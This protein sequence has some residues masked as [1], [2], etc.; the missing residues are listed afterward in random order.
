MNFDSIDLAFGGGAPCVI[1]GEIGVNHN[2]DVDILMRL[3]E[4]GA[5]AGLDVLKLQHFVAEEEI[6]RYAPS[7]DY[8]AAGGHADGQLALA[9]ALELSGETLVKA[10]ARCRALGVGFLCSVFDPVSAAFVAE[11]LGCKSVKIASSE[12]GAEPFLADL[13]RKFDGLILSTGASELSETARAVETLRAH[14]TP[15]DA[16][17]IAVMHCVSEYPAPMRD[18]NLKTMAALEIALGVPVGFS[19]HTEGLVAGV[20]AAALGAAVLEKHYTLDKALP[21]PDHK[22]SAD[23]AEITAYVRAVRDAEAAL[24][25]GRKTPAPSEAGNRALIRKSLVCAVEALA[26]GA[27]IEPSMLAA[28][29][30]MVEGAVLPG[31]LSKIVGLTLRRPKSADEPIFWADFHG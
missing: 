23:I 5:R 9:K 3:I 16:Q 12:V 15:S 7:A 21:G 27:V 6:S 26:P 8:Q 13:A 18:L 2:N 30:P 11:K 14:R 1:I 24:G 19:D 25:D 22:A 17:E 31:D 29:R 4:E 20:A 28:K 10:Q